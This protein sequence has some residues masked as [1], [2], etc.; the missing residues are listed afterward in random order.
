MT[1]GAWQ[2]PIPTNPQGGRTSNPHR[3]AGCPS[4]GDNLHPKLWKGAG[5]QPP[6]FSASTQSSRRNAEQIWGGHTIENWAALPQHIAS[7]KVRLGWKVACYE[8]IRR[9][10]EEGSPLLMDRRGPQE[11]KTWLSLP[12]HGFGSPQACP[13]APSATDA[14]ICCLFP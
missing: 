5:G 6:K 7:L 14:L 4:K 10:R 12:S 9:K 13:M 8:N 3:L 11:G 1:A 2:G